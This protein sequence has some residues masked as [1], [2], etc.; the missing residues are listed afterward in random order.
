[1]KKFISILLLLALM[2]SFCA[3]AADDTNETSSVVPTEETVGDTVEETVDIYY[4]RP[5]L[6]QVLAQMELDEKAQQ[7]PPEQLYGMFDQTVPINGVYKI[8]N[9]EGVQ[10]MAEH[11]DAHFELLC[12]IDMMGATVKAIGTKE[13]PFTGVIDG[14]NATISNFTVEATDDGYLGFLGYSDGGSLQRI[15]LENVTYVPKENTKYMGGIAGYSTTEIKGCTAIGIMDVTAAA[16]GAVCGGLVGQINGDIVNSVAQ[17]NI[18]YTAAGSATIGGLAGICEN[19]TVEF[20]ETYGFLDIAG[21]N[22]KVGLLFGQAKN[23]KLYTVSYLGEKNSVDGQ[24]FANYFGEEQD[25]T[26]EVINVRDNTPRILPEAQQKLR[27]RVVDEMNAMGTIEWYTS[28]NLYHDCACLL[29][30]CHG[31][32]EAGKLHV[33]IPYNHKGG[34]MERFTYCLD[35]TNTVVDWVYPFGSYDGFDLYIGNDCST[36]VQQ[37]WWTVS[38]SS[39]VIRCTYMHPKYREQNGCIPVGEWNWVEGIDEKGKAYTGDYTEPYTNASG[40][41]V[42]YEAYALMHKGDAYASLSK[43]G[44]HTRMVVEEPVVV[45]DENGK[46][47]GK[48]SYVVSTE[49]GGPNITEPYYCS[50]SVKKAYTFQQLFDTGKLPIT[51][52]ELITGEMEPVEVTIADDVDGKMGMVNGVITANYCLDGTTLKVTDSQGNVAFDFTMFPTVDKYLL[53]NDSDSGIRNYNDTFKMAMF[54]SALQNVQ[55]ENGESYEYTVTVHLTT[56]DDIVIKTGSFVQ[57]QA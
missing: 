54:A 19:G 35:D 17:V 32:Y 3:C 10:L 23:L 22:K 53:A 39:D 1:M 26:Y 55:F 34:S 42:M 20:D 18:T 16:D 33:G 24:L 11:P 56:G 52:E 37:A 7:T 6:E 4:N 46:I 38:N 5:T 36:A 49:Q 41:Q 47:D 45:R 28:Q 57:G 12:N 40:S 51:I 27:D 8:W 44:G 29:S 15:K 13:R 9:A 48:L 43:D 25:V 30:I 2:L 21:G 31:I 50:W 14:V